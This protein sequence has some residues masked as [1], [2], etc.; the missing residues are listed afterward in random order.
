MLKLVIRQVK[1]DISV[2]VWC[3]TVYLEEHT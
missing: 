2:V 1:I 3:K